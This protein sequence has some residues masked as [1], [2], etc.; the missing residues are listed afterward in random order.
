M[1]R[2]GLKDASPR[3]FQ[4]ARSTGPPGP[5]LSLPP[6]AGERLRRRSQPEWVPPM[7]AVLTSEPFSREGWLFERKLDGERCLAFRRGAR[8]RLLSRS[9]LMLNDTYPELV[10]ALKAQVCD[11]FVVDGEV[12]AFEGRRTSFARLQQRMQLR[13]PEQARVTPVRVFYYLFDL[14]FLDGWDTTELELRHRKSLLR[15]ALTSRD[16]LRYLP[17]RNAAGEAYYLEACRRGWEGLVA[18]RGSAPYQSRR[19]RDWLK[20]KCANQQEFVIGGYTEPRGSRIGFGALL[21]G[22]YED[23]LLRY[24]GKVGTGFSD[25]TLR[26]L[27]GRLAALETGRP[28]FASSDLPRNGV[29]WVRPELVAEIGFAELTRERK[30]RHPRFLGL[31]RDKPA[32]EVSLEE[33]TD[34]PLT[35]R[36]YRLRPKTEDQGGEDRRPPRAR[37]SR[38]R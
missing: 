33:P 23:G 3:P 9:G 19:S 21:V 1:E 30:L 7:L 18:K 17:H 38:D 29:H 31:R 28:P 34:R 8:L 15:R 37:R 22:Y 25:E 32:R 2:P 11:E 13:A 14:L 26:D 35:G 27:A 5:L 20:L 6:E 16:P 12:V 4:S 36:R 10:E 24:A